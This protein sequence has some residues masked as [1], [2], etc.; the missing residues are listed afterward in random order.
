MV[1]V[2]E[3]E[4]IRCLPV[5]VVASRFLSW[6][7]LTLE[8]REEC[9]R[10]LICSG[11]GKE[12]AGKPA[13]FLLHAGQAGWERKR[14]E[15]KTFYCLNVGHEEDAWALGSGICQCHMLGKGCEAEAQQAVGDRCLAHTGKAASHSL[16]ANSP[17]E[18]THRGSEVSPC[19]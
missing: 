12:S 5:W 14:D 15:S 8:S 3:C 18:Q 19:T 17:C 2:G 4:G 10:A 6:A 1:P 7:K 11:V 16:M 9:F 13:V